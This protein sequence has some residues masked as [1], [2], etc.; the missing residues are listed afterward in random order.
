MKE[1]NK[2][3]TTLSNNKKLGEREKLELELTTARVTIAH[4]ENKIQVIGPLIDPQHGDWGSIM[5]NF[6]MFV[7]FERALEGIFDLIPPKW[8]R[9][10]VKDRILFS[11]VESSLGLSEHR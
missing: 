9:A 7:G 3:L 1:S 5:C 8:V 11:T 6:S 2:K 4:Q 10:H